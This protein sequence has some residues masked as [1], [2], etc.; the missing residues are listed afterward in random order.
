MLFDCYAKIRGSRRDKYEYIERCV[1]APDL[2]M[3]FKTNTLQLPRYRATHKS[4]EG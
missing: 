4:L 3:G 1:T 2:S